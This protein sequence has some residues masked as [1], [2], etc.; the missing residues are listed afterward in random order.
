MTAIQAFMKTNPIPF[1]IIFFI[2]FVLWRN[3]GF[4]PLALIVLG[5]GGWLVCKYNET[6][7]QSQKVRESGS[8]V[9]VSMTKRV[10][11]ANKLVDIARNYGDHEKLTHI[12][13]AQNESMSAAI[14]HSSQQ[15]DQVL[16]TVMSMARSYP[17]LRANQ[18]YQML[19][20]QL[21]QIEN[22]LQQK[23]EAYNAMV[24]TYNTSLTQIPFIF[25]A[26]PLGFRSAAYFDVEDASSL[27][28]LKDFQTDDGAILKAM[29]SQAGSRVVEASKVL[30][31]DLE[32][33]GRQLLEKGKTIADQ[34]SESS[35]VNEVN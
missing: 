11:L 5:F 15:V 10:D 19:M 27:E 28:S 17:E 22:G 13:V 33:A 30:S 6:Q 7:E 26:Q 35:S 32:L 2:G 14:A 8:N 24:R 4:V 1:L 23:R 29:L 25:F 34:P 3:V 9:Q 16:S 31:S 12:T 20:Q 18:T 21:E